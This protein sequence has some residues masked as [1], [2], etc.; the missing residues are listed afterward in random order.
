[1]ISGVSIYKR[2]KTLR[3]LQDLESARRFDSRKHVG[4]CEKVVVKHTH[5]RANAHTHFQSAFI[6]YPIMG[7]NF[8][9]AL[10]AH[11]VA[12]FPDHICFI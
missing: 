9:A 2:G 4:S 5:T 12:P 11:L 8:C 3:F 1:M 7:V 6:F 10:L